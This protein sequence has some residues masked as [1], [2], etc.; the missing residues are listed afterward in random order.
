MCGITSPIA[1]IV[2][3]MGAVVVVVEDGRDSGGEDSGGGAGLEETSVD[4]VVGTSTVGAI[5]AVA[6]GPRASGRASSAGQNIRGAQ[7]AKTARVAPSAFRKLRKDPYPPFPQPAC[8]VGLRLLFYRAR[9]PAAIRLS[10]TVG[11]AVV[12]CDK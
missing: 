8:Q 2:T 9:P 10:C 7:S 12:E 3:C 1:A 6:E 4:V 11:G 5:V